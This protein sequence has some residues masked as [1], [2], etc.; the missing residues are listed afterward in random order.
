MTGVAPAER[1]YDEFIMD[2]ILES[3]AF[4]KKEIRRRNYCRM[5]L[6]ALT[7]SDLTTTNGD[8]LDK[9][10]LDGEGLLISSVT[11]WLTVHQEV[12]SQ[13]EWVLWKRA[14]TLWSRLDGS[15]IHP[16]GAW[17]LSSRDSRIVHI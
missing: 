5:Y 4:T 15:L 12:P 13:A 7:I 3:K 17:N 2:G 16:L 6:G 11:K 9:A 1:Q 10:K 14:N 8:R